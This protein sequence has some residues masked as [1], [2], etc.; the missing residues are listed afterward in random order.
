MH[1]GDERTVKWKLPIRV[2]LAARVESRFI[3]PMTRKPQYGMRAKLINTLLERWLRDN[4]SDLD[5]APITEEEIAKLLLSPSDE[6]VHV[7]V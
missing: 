2:S 7:G 3:D 4:P 5:S 6:N 1:K